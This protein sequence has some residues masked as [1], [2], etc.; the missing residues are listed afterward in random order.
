LGRDISPRQRIV[1]EVIP[2]RR[3][4]GLTAACCCIAMGQDAAAEPTTRVRRGVE[5]H[6]R[7]K[8]A[9]IMWP[10]T[11]AVLE[12]WH[13]TVARQT[14]HRWLAEDLLAANVVQAAYTR[15]KWAR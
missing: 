14:L 15:W 7:S 4:L 12:E 9:R 2:A 6:F 13:K 8:L 11:P 10:F 5:Q 3:S 1:A